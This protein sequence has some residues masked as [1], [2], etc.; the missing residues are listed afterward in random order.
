MR[1]IAE[2]ASSRLAAGIGLGAL[3]LAL[4]GYVLLRAG[5]PPPAAEPSWLAAYAQRPDAASQLPRRLLERF[6]PGTSLLP[7]VREL[8]RSGFTCTADTETL[9]DYNCALRRLSPDGAG[10]V[11]LRLVASGLN[12]AAVEVAGQPGAQRVARMR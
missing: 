11:T 8:E 1:R 10:R 9:S 5:E 7:V 6:A 12:L 3:A 2:L 4:T